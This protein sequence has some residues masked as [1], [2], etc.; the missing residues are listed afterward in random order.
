MLEKKALQAGDSTEVGLGP[1][2]IEMGGHR[3]GSGG[4]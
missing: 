1:G 2:M 4:H 3:L